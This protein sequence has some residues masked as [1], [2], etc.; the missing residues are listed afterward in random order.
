MPVLPEITPVQPAWRESGARMR[1]GSPIFAMPDRRKLHQMLL[2]LRRVLRGLGQ[3]R[4]YSAAVIVT[5][6]LTIGTTTAIFSA[7]YAIL[8]KPLPM[9]RPEALVICWQ[10]APERN[11]SVVELSYR[12]FEEWRLHSRSLT[13]AAAVG[14]STWPGVLKRGEPAR[15]ATAGVSASFFATLGAA[16]PSAARSP[17]TTMFR[18]PRR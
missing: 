2:I 11:L 10:R 1:P 5:L 13:T 9:T 16:R 12:A 17:R 6:A 18:M 8:L 7:V 4:G 14:S 3:Q 15:V